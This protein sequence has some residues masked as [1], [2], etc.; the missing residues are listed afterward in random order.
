MN[1]RSVPYEVRIG[2]HL[3]QHWAPWFAGMTFTHEPDGSTAL[4][5]D[6]RDQAEL[7]GLIAK[8][9]DLGATLISLTALDIAAYQEHRHADEFDPETGPG[10]TRSPGDSA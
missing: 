5:G 6:V 4:R 3:D 7:H 9:R 2:G 1:V 10:N 8:V